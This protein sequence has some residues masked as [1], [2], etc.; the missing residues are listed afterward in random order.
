MLVVHHPD[1]ALHDPELVFRYGQ[2][3][4]QPDRAERYRIF[5][6]VARRGGHEI[7]TAP[8]AGLDAVLAVHDPDYVTFL[9]TAWERWH[10]IP[11]TGPDAIPNVHP[12]HRMHRKPTSLIGQLGWY[13]NST[14]CPIQRDT[15]PAVR[16]SAWSAVHA[17][18]QV[19]ERG[20][21]AYALCR[22]PGH[23]AYPDLMTGVCYLNNAA[24][25]AELLAR[26]RGRVAVLDIDVHHCNGTQHI[27][28]TRP[29]VL[30][31]SIHADP[32]LTAPFYA[33]HADEIGEGEG[34][35]CNMNMPLPFGTADPAFLHHLDGALARIRV[36]APAVLVVSL[37]FDASEHDPVETF[38]VSVEGFGEAAGRIAAL[39]LPTLL[40]Q[41]GGYLSARLGDNLDAF[42]RGFEA[43]SA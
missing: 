13:S 33:G 26:A 5:L 43:G 38:K 29:D 31:C 2:F 7:V 20:G 12:T 22:P 14:S 23:H 34:R 40:V 10:E 32:N 30:V 6:D 28:W 3:I 8:D 11:G 24:V 37:G 15:W 17:A 42:L 27:F 41:E 19:A 35:G 21:S 25:A 36:F 39:G 16:A 18:R 4:A 9:R 1:Q